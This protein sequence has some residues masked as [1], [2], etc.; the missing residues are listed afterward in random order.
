MLLIKFDLPDIIELVIYHF[1]IYFLVVI[2]ILVNPTRI[3]IMYLLI[4]VYY[5]IWYVL[6]SNQCGS[7]TFFTN[8]IISTIYTTMCIIF[9]IFAN[10]IYWK[11]NRYAWLLLFAPIVYFLTIKTVWYILKC[12]K[13]SNITYALGVFKYIL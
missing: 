13:Y 4:Y 3:T 7:S 1:Y 12:P 8:V 2:F 9:Y 6:S 11:H 5:V 10:Y